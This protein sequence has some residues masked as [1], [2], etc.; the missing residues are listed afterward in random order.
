M[1]RNVVPRSKISF[2][3]QEQDPTQEHTI[4]FVQKTSNKHS[5]TWSDFETVEQGLNA[6]ISIFEE[7]LKEMNPQQKQINYDITELNK[8]I[9][10]L[11]DLG[12]LV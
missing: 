9:D 6:I 1:A 7:R 5:R 11:G 2:N 12:V 8:F 4:L 3:Q 10:E